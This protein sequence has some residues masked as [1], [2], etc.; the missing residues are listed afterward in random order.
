MSRTFKLTDGAELIACQSCAGLWTRRVQRGR[1]P[2]WCPQCRTRSCEQ[3]GD[4][5]EFTGTNRDQRF[6]SGSCRS[7]HTARVIGT[8]S[9]WSLRPCGAEGCNRQAGDSGWCR[10]HYQRVRVHGHWRLGTYECKDCG[11]EFQTDIEDGHGMSKS[12][13]Y[14]CLTGECKW[15]DNR[16][17]WPSASDRGEQEFCSKGCLGAWRTEQCRPI[18]ECNNCGKSYRLQHSD[19]SGDYCSREC[20]FDDFDAWYGGEGWREPRLKRVGERDGWVCGL[21]GERVDRRCKWPH[22][23]A[24][25]VDHIVPVSKGGV[26]E[27][28]NLQ[29]AH[30]GCNRR[31]RDASWGSQLR[32]PMEAPPGVESL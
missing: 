8:P 15:C 6:C 28:W 25:T 13:C 27:M 10:R 18:C 32:L 21:C 22:D 14:W 7:K 31:K 1:K 16:F 12:R 23:R 11:D 24:P 19:R 2:K 20:A 3:C 17:R 30:W 29:V 4:E 5:F 26:D 9:T